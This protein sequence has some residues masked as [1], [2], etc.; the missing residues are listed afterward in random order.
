MGYIDTSIVALQEPRR[1]LASA[2][3]HHRTGNLDDA[4]RDYLAV[5][6]HGYRV[7]DVLPLVAGLAAARGDVH[8]ALEH[9]TL[10]LQHQPAHVW[11]LTE[12]G[13]LLHRLGR[14][15]DAAKCLEAAHELDPANPTILANLGVA[16][17]D[18][19]RRDDAMRA[20]RRLSSLKPGNPLVQHQ[21]RRAASAI[22]P[23]WHVPML[24]DQA[25]N[26][27]F[28]RAI[29]QAVAAHGPD[30]RI[31]DIGAGSG[32]LSM[33]A[34]RAGAGNVVCCESVPAI[35]ETAEEI[36]AING[37]ADRIRIIAKKSDKLVVGEDLDG[38]ADILIS[39]ILSC[40]VLAEHVLATFED[41]LSRL[42]HEDATIIPRAVTA[43]GCLIESEVLAKHAHVQNVSGFDVAPFGALAAQ[44]VPVHGSMTSW[45][46]L[47]D[48]HDLVHIDLEA[49]RHDSATW[50]LSIPVRADGIAIGVLQWMRVDLAEGIEFTNSP[51]EC[52][53]GGWLQLLH[54]FPRPISVCAGEQ[55]ELTVGH[56]RTS[57]ILVPAR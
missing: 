11:G 56:D 44:R 35:A 22:V 55:V 48:D 26:D 57:L 36:V 6:K 49:R 5:L 3:D 28:D 34:A 54:T 32:L 42:V 20:Y 51:D 37:Y 46:R 18:A 23:F 43:R 39:E 15:S 14:W 29:R 1:L 17:T 8:A 24:N 4:E 16:L 2:M 47:S 30:A 38:R 31:L 52:C 25:R 7:T 19:G 9:W 33:M 50:K 10:V 13:A 41:A 45:R 27:A 12:K 40:D 53:A 21:M